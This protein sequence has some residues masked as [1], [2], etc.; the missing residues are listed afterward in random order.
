MSTASA[1]VGVCRRWVQTAYLLERIE[2]RAIYMDV[3]TSLLRPF[4]F[5]S[6]SCVRGA[7]APT[8]R[9][10][11]K[12][13]RRATASALVADTARARHTGLP[14]NTHSPRETVSLAHRQGKALAAHFPRSAPPSDNARHTAGLERNPDNGKG[15][16][17]TVTQGRFGRYPSRLKSGR[18]VSR[19]ALVWLRLVRHSHQ[20]Y[21]SSNN[22]GTSCGG[23]R[24]FGR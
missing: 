3:C 22:P 13:V 12:R 15:G 21:R 14:S 1:F 10:P 9:Q 8:C 19:H 7:D 23:R 11:N 5:H 24:A 4:L 18:S 2:Y 6:P 16:N 20:C 17:I